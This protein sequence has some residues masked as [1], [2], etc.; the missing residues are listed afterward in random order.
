[1]GRRLLLLALV[2]ACGCG[3]DK[4]KPPPKVQ[5]RAPGANAL[6]EKPLYR[7]EPGQRTPCT[8]GALCEARLA[9]S[10]L[11][12]YHINERYPFKFNADA[13]AGITV[14]GAGTF[15]REDAKHGTMTIMFRAARRGPA[16]LSGTFKLSVCTEE[17]CEIDEPKLAFDV[18]VD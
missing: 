18:A 17:N 15:A 11:G 16:K 14:D 12:D 7:I 2:A 9:F 1:M 8:P 5:D 3:R 4:A 13:I 6:V 10:A